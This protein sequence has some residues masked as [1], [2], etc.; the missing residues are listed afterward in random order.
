MSQVINSN[1][2]I[3]I[4]LAAYNQRWISGDD[5]I[6]ETDMGGIIFVSAP[7]TVTLP[8]VASVGVGIPL[9]IKNISSEGPVI[10]A[11]SGA[12]LID[13]DNTKTIAFQ[14]SSMTLMCDGSAWRVI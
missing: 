7:A 1:G 3:L 9:T 5:A 4:S 11:A 6:L 14:Y 2:E 8:D 12:E 10:V 13:G